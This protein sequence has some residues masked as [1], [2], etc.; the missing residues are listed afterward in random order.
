MKYTSQ[1]L[2]ILFILYYPE[3]VIN[4]IDIFFFVFVVG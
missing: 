2:N 1:Q 3:K 4:L